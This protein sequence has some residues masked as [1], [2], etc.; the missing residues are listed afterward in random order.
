MGD[1]AASDVIQ[2]PSIGDTFIWA[3]SGKASMASVVTQYQTFSLR[4]LEKKFLKGANRIRN[5][6]IDE[7]LQLTWAMGLAGIG[8]VAFA[9]IRGQTIRDEEKR[10]EFYKNAMGYNSE[11]GEWDLSTLAVGALKRS[12]YMAAPA[13]AYD[14]VGTPLGLPY[15]GLGRT[16]RET[17][18]DSEERP[19]AWRTGDLGETMGNFPALKFGSQLKGAAANTANLL[20]RGDLDEDQVERQKIALLRNLKGILPNDPATQGALGWLMEHGMY[21]R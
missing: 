11:S 10:R 2:R 14:T 1:L 5:R 8:V 21:E 7:A 6:D 9:A 3:D 17:E 18:L 16:T 20:L 15:A 13:M 19:Q 4:S 12:S